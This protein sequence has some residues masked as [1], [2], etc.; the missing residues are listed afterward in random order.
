MN[1]VF[2]AA[3]TTFKLCGIC[4][5]SGASFITCC[6]PKLSHAVQELFPAELALCGGSELP[7]HHQNTHAGR[8][9][10]QVITELLDPI[11]ADLILILGICKG[12]EG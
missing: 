10:G 8:V 4:P 3:L 2:D 7:C 9:Q 6:S 11:N 1:C 12:N 5:L